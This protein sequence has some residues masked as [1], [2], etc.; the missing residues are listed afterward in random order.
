M[1][2]LTKF[3]SIVDRH[4]GLSLWI[5]FQNAATSVTNLYKGEIPGVRLFSVL[6]M[7]AMSSLI[8]KLCEIQGIE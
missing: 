7:P 1:N 6:F 2:I 8:V 3:G 5:P 4:H